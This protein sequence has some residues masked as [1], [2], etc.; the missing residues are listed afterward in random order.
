[1][2]QV[3]CYSIA[4]A[5]I[6]G[7]LAGGAMKLGPHALQRDLSGP[8]ILISRDS[9]R[10]VP[11]DDW[12]EATN[13]ASYKGEIP[14]YVLGTDWTRPVEYGAFIDVY[15][16]SYAY[17]AD[18]EY[19]PPPEEEATLQPAIFVAP[20]KISSPPPVRKPVSYP[21]RDGDILG[22]AGDEEH[23][24]PTVIAETAPS[25]SRSG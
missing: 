17:V 7:L 11:V 13:F 23:V 24:A 6:A 16:D 2:K 20:V 25:A 5:G 21:S 8:Q 10:T 4:T 19:A 1:M 3:I 14:E 18:A 12:P 22:G 9:D 15:D